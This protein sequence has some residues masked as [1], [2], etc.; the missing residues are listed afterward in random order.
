MVV[1]DLT[2]HPAERI[3]AGDALLRQRVES[4]IR[5][6]R[7]WL[8]PAVALFAWLSF[9]AFVIPVDHDE[10]VYSVVA[11]GI[12]EGHWPYRDFFDNK[13]PLVYVWY[14]PVAATA[15]IELQRIFGA[16]LAA[17]SV[18]AMAVIAR[19]WFDHRYLVRI[20]I[21]YALALGNPYTGAGNSIETF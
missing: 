5:A 1:L 19:R 4:V 18:G 7:Y 2:A 17:L 20:V 12:L 15:H 11:H 8:L 14:L 13:P 16:A 21:A 9:L 3:D 6:E 10:A